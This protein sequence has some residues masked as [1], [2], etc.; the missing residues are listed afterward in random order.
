MRPKPWHHVMTGLSAAVLLGVTLFVV[1]HY[2]ALPEQI[3]THFGPGG[4]ADAFGP[5]SGIFFPLVMGWFLLA[6]ITVVSFFPSAWNVPGNSPRTLAAAADMIAVL[7]LVMALMFVWM[8]LCSALGRG[9]GVWFLPV[10]LA[11]VFAPLVYLL[12]QAARD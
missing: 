1:I 10:S 4:Q 3:P 11:G 6:L 2:G 9:L 5:K 12:V 8:T 7:R